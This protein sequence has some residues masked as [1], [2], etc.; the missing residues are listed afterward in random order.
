M[1]RAR[2]HL[3]CLSVTPYYHVTSRCVRRAFLCG[4]D[5][6]SG[7]SYE[8]RRDWIETRIRVLS[9][10]FSIRV[11]AYAVMSN[12]YHLVVH[13]HPSEATGWSEQD[14]LKRW[15]ALFRG[16]LL[17]QKAVAGERLSEAEQD[18]LRSIVTVYR[19]RLSS[20]S[21]FMKCLNEPIARKANAEDH[22][23]GHFWEARFHSQALC[24]DAAILSAMAYVD[25]NPIRAGIASTPESSDHTSIRA[26]IRGE[27]TD[28][29]WV[30]SISTLIRDGDLHS[31]EIPIRALMAFSDDE[32]KETEPR[33]P[34]HD[35][36]Y[37]QLLDSTGRYARRHKRG[38]IDPAIAPVLERLG[39]S[40]E[41]WCQAS[42]CFRQVYRKGNL[43][44]K[45]PA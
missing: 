17:V 12:H 38:R 18:T 16:P 28:D 43:R 29:E 1:P 42:T 34:M 10:L 35:R 4:K 23:T 7:K 5:R 30:R 27:K 32:V 11:C 40:A 8:H 26:R 21:W 20:L 2:K 37:L 31:L 36:D 41:E 14:V 9:S 15:A 45:K 24:S 25:L 19:Q 22:C 13:L 33:L 6:Y 39:L 3:V 44:L